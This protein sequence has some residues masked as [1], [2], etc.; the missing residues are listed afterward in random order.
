M[1][2]AFVTSNDGNRG[3]RPSGW[4]ACDS[5]SGRQV[6][7]LGELWSKPM[8]L[9]CDSRWG[10]FRRKRCPSWSPN[11]P[12]GGRTA[13]LWRCWRSIRGGLCGHVCRAVCDAISGARGRSKLRKRWDKRKRWRLPRGSSPN[14]SG[15]G[16]RASASSNTNRTWTES[17]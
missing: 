1:A 7:R 3:T 11:V 6:L 2:K 14:P 12:P 15:R 10:R 17:W 16:G 5:P 13:R 4:T 8:Q 9:L